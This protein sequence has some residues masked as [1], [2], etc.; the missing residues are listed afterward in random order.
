MHFEAEF[1][2]AL[3]SGELVIGPVRV[4]LDRETGSQMLDKVR[5][6]VERHHCARVT[7]LNVRIPTLEW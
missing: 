6:Q 1:T 7:A 4:T 3:D 5:R 2:A